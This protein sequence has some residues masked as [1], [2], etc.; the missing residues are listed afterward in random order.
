LVLESHGIA[1]VTSTG[2]AGAFKAD[3]APEF[4]SIPEVFV[5]FD[6][7]AAGRHGARRVVRLIPHAKLVELPD[8]VGEGGDV[9]D[10]FVRLGKTREE[11][12]ELLEIAQAVPL[13][14][15]P[16]NLPAVSATG[17]P[18]DS[19][20]RVAEL[21]AS[22]PIAD[23]VAAYVP[24][25]PA[26]KTLRGLCPF[27]DDHRPSLV[28]YSATGTYHCFGCGSH[29]DVISFLMAIAG[30]SFS[31]ALAALEEFR[32]RYDRRAAARG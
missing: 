26:G 25:R 24:L 11:F 29:G 10:F 9:T 15:V 20:R 13:P 1:A 21:K 19:H 27:H 17:T 3:W 6:R 12:L 5:C 7:D 28:V 23:V 16:P 14:E 18:S 32:T 22:V 2:G 8:D 31:Q 30:L 4:T